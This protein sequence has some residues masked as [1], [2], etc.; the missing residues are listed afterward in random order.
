MFTPFKKLVTWE[1]G[2]IDKQCLLIHHC[3]IYQVVLWFQK[4]EDKFLLKVCVSTHT[5]TI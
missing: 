1:F 4:S 2:K 5:K 3:R